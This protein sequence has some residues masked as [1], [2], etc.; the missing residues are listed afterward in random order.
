MFSNS[1]ISEF[2]PGGGG[3]QFSKTFEIQKMPVLSNGGG[4][5]REELFIV[6]D[7]Y[8]SIT[9]LSQNLNVNNVKIC[10]SSQN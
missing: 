7:L 6:A 2:N 1:K 4:E 9:Q 3:Q 8:L 10:Q 5:W